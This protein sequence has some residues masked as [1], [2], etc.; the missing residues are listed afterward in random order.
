MV[1]CERGVYVHDVI[2]ERAHAGALDD[3]SIIPLGHV[4]LIS[5]KITTQKL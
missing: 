2:M 3:R 4:I 1:G 5:S